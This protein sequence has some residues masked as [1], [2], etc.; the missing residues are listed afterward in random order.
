MVTA[1]SELR[2]GV[3]LGFTPPELLESEE[4]D[5]VQTGENGRMHNNGKRQM[6]PQY[7]F[8]HFNVSNK[9]C[10]LQSG[11]EASGA[12]MLATVS[13]QLAFFFFFV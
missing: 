11:C 3:G 9:L 7:V 12:Q 10:M 6:T 5:L 2:L 4:T 1:N 8:M 13:C